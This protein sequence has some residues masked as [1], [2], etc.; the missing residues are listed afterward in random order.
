M[1]FL[2]T[3]EVLCN[4]TIFV[5]RSHGSLCD[6][7]DMRSCLKILWTLHMFHMH[8]TDYCKLDSQ[9]VDKN[10]S[11]K[12]STLNFLHIIFI[13]WFFFFL[14]GKADREGGKPMEIKVRKLDING[15]VAKPDWVGTNEFIPP[16]VFYS[17]S[18]PL[19]ETGNGTASSVETKGVCFLLTDN[20][21]E[22]NIAFAML[23]IRSNRYRFCL[24]ISSHQWK[25]KWL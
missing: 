10:F 14:A 19:P 11:T 7:P 22:T 1:S 20:V 8:I 6:L 15:F 5:R 4:C 17:H 9:K 18:R 16:C 21:C 12:F 23:K 2:A 24:L 25:R 3:N 13:S